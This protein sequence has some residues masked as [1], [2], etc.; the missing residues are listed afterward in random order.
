MLRKTQNLRKKHFYAKH[1][2]VPQRE[3]KDNNKERRR[4]RLYQSR[5]RRG[6]RA[7]IKKTETKVP[8]REEKDDNEESGYRGN[9]NQANS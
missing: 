4:Q 7:T 6:R 2:R 1:A 9:T 8:L 5:D 3:E